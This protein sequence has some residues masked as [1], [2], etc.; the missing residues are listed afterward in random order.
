[1]NNINK[2][3]HLAHKMPKN[4]TLDQKIKWHEGHANNCQCRDSKAHLIKLKNQK[5][6]QH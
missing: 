2:E 5:K 6:S 1:M 4:A 3:W